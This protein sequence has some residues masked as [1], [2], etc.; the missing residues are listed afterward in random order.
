MGEIQSDVNVMAIFSCLLSVSA[1]FMDECNFQKA[2]TFLIF[3]F[4][5]AEFR[6]RGV[7]VQVIVGGVYEPLWPNGYG[8]RRRSWRVKIDVVE[9]PGAYR[10]ISYE[11]LRKL[12]LIV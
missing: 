3:Y 5:H 1:L 8:A 10:A 9:S 4:C 7:N 6:F 12:C 2:P 11:Q